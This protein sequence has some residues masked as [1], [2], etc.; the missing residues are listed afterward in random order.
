MGSWTSLGLMRQGRVVAPPAGR[1]II[2]GLHCN[3]SLPLFWFALVRDPDLGGPWAARVRAVFAN[4]DDEDGIPPLAL[5]WSDAQRNLSRAA[6]R[7]GFRVPD[8]ASLFQEWAAVL[9]ADAEQGRVDAVELELSSYVGS[10]RDADEFLQELHGYVEVWHGDGRVDVPASQDAGQELTG[11]RGYS[12]QPYPRSFP[13]LQ[14]EHIQLPLEQP[15][16]G[17]PQTEQAAAPPP[18]PTLRQRTA[19]LTE[20]VLS[21][22]FVCGL[23]WL[24]DLLFGKTGFFAGLGIGTVLYAGFVITGE[25]RK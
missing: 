9:Q 19:G 6:A 24:G 17:Q 2:P 4:E 3:Y 23:G 18:R 7:A 15:S 1:G 10:S 8:L 12:G 11:F 22:A 13:G 14:P 20:A 21:V 25:R 16:P 5:A